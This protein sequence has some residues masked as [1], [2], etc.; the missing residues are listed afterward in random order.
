MSVFFV[1]SDEAGCYRQHRFE[2]FL[3][4]HPFY[5]RAYLIIDAND[6]TKLNS[7][8]FSVKEKYGISKDKEIKWSYI[9]SLRKSKEKGTLS[10]KDVYYFL[11]DFEEEDLIDF[12]KECLG[13]LKC[14]SCC[15]LI[16]TITF[17]S[18]DF[19]G[20]INDASLYKMHLQDAMQRIEM[21]I[22]NDDNNLAIIF[23]DPVELRNDSMLRQ[24]YHEVY[25]QGDFIRKYKHIKDSLS[26]ELSHHSIG[27]QIVDYCAG[28][29]NSS[30]KGYSVAKDI[31]KNYIWDSIRTNSKNGDPYGFGIVEVP[32]NKDVRNEIKKKIDLI[33]DD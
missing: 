23:L 31:F 2:R 26:F 10:E 16:F 27:I 32:K 18:L 1:F 24:Y 3:M 30:L 11:K 20:Q 21:E 6:W 9:W 33:I 7:Q 19:T 15:K 29:F 12:V 14:C 25:T 17:N 13:I 28:I 5:V 8:Y 4:A 22:Q